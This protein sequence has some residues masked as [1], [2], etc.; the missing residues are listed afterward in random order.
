MP[1]IEQWPLTVRA[2]EQYE[3]C[4]AR[5]I[6]GPWA[7]LLIE[8]AR[9]AA[10]ERVLDVACGTGVVARAAAERVGRTGRVVGI[11]LNSGMIAVARSLA[12]ID[13]APIEWLERSALDLGLDNASF[14]V[15][16]CQQGL[17][18]FPDKTVALREMR[19]VLAGHGRLALSVWNT[20]GIYNTAVTAALAQ[21][22]GSDIAARFNASRNTPTA[23]ELRQLVTEAGFSDVE[24]SVS[25]INVHVPQIEKFVLDHLLATPVASAVASVDAEARK[26]IGA[27]VMQ[28]LQSYTDGDR[29]TYPEET[30]IV[31]GQVR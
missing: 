18:F 29:I 5:Y 26:Q 1:T 13:G 9:L 20:V 2:A 19:R 14:D 31:T 28:Q 8:T 3:R 12:A 7:P 30:H 11:D 10:G 16:L 27:S 17:Q 6:L 25:R 22:V 4:P 24:V 21:F 23:D 15:V